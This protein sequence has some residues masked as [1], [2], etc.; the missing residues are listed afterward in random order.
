MASECT[1]IAKVGGLGDV[2]GSL[3]K[4]LTELGLD[5]R[6]AIP[7]Y[8]VIDEKKYP[9][10]L[11]ASGVKVNGEK[12]DIYQTFLP[13]SQIILYLLDN[14]KHFAENNIYF[15]RTAFVGS[16]K[17]IERFLFFSKSVLE[18]FPALNWSPS[19]IHCNDWHTAIVAPLLKIK[20]FT[21]PAKFAGGARKALCS[22]TAKIKNIKTLLTIHNLA[23]QGKWQAGEILN[24][25]GLKGDELESL[26]IRDKKG[27]FNILQQGIINSHLLNTVSKNY[28]KEILTQE[29]GEGLENWLLLRQKNLFGVLNGIDY[30]RFNPETDS[31][32]KANYSFK[33][34]DKKIENKIDL[35]KILKF[36]KNPQIPLLGIINRLTPQ[37]G[38]DLIIEIIPEI[39]KLNCQLVILGV[40]RKDYERKLLELS[41]KYPKNISTQ[42]KFDPILA[43]KIY[44]GVDIFLMPS[45]FEPCGL[46]QMISMRYGTIPIARKTGGLADTVKNKKTGFLFKEYKSEALLKTVKEALEFYENPQKW[47]KFIKRAMTEDFSWKKSAK[48]YLKLYKKLIK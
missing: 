26:K 31:Y 32:L 33:N 37:K 47:Q 42:I 16:F 10:E 44:A 15:G 35:Q 39:V 18:I 41:Y 1:P 36:Q 23:N 24:F 7:R 8:G 9:S 17:E 20:N 4:A 5:V 27:D 25:L 38:V 29:Y 28:A 45:K 3:P 22:D 48:E 21:P 6:V 30:D 11:I 40:G 46:G 13:G 43:Q 34:L 12:I 19:M 14:K 2:I